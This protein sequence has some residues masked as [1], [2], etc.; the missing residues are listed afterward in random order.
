MKNYEFN[1]GENRKVECTASGYPIPSALW[2]RN[3]R[4]VSDFG[5]NSVYQ[6]RSGL[7]S[8]L[9]FRNVRNAKYYVFIQSAPVELTDYNC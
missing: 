1:H 4:S 5:G 8:T 2:I 9:R 6:I 7:T 3:Q